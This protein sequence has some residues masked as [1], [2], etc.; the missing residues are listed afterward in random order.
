MR[1][2]F[3]VAELGQRREDDP[4]GGIEPRDGHD[5]D[6]GHVVGAQL[7]Y[8][9]ASTWGYA[10]DG[11]EELDPVECRDLADSGHRELMLGRRPGANEAWYRVRLFVVPGGSNACRAL[12]DREHRVDAANQTFVS[13]CPNGR[14]RR[15]DDR[16]LDRPEQR[17]PVLD[18]CVKHP[19]PFPA[20]PALGE[21]PGSPL[22][23]LGVGVA[24]PGERLAD[25]GA[26]HP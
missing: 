4:L 14:H 11:L 15:F 13:A 24:G 8:T 5:L 23:F 17:F 1:R 10:I 20:M 18:T 12:I 2:R 22:D 26:S 21:H 25:L 7:E 6:H 19:L 9:A 16:L 3:D